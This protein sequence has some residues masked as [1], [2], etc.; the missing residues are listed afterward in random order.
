MTAAV[1]NAIVA[2]LQSV[3]NIGRV[4]AF[5]RYDANLQALASQYRATVGTREQ[6]RGW[7]V[8]CSASRQLSPHNGRLVI[9][10][11]WQIRGYLGLDDGAQ[12]ELV[13]D[14][15][16]RT[17]RGAFNADQT[18][19]GTVAGFVETGEDAQVGL[20]V[21]ELAPVMF[22]GVLCHLA[23]LSLQTVRYE[24]LP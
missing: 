11:T 17:I 3:A 7:F 1:R 6:I 10:D 23:R 8:T 18:L 13:M 24:P 12:T 21:E 2:R 15:L 4:H 14:A 9:Q 22:A 20:Q 19:A 5:Q 16:V